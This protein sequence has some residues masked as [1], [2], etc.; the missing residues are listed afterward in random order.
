MGGGTELPVTHQALGAMQTGIRR[1]VK[2]PIS[3]QKCSASSPCVVGK[4]KGRALLAFKEQKSA[5]GAL[6]ESGSLGVQSS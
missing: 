5:G 3:Q 2:L 1:R 6:W 4:S